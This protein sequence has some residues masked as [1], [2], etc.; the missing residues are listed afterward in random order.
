[1]HYRFARK[2]FERILQKEGG[3]ALSK[4]RFAS[5]KKPFSEA[6]SRNKGATDKK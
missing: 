3:K 5:L 4:G 1:L 2:S 6:K